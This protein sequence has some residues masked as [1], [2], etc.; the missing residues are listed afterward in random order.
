MTDLPEDVRER[1]RLAAI[2]ADADRR[3]VGDH[4]L[5]VADAAAAVAYEAGVAARTVRDDSR[6]R[7]T[8]VVAALDDGERFEEGFNRAYFRADDVADGEE[9][10]TIA[11]DLAALLGICGPAEHPAAQS[12]SRRDPDVPVPPSHAVAPDAIAGV[13]REGEGPHRFPGAESAARGGDFWTSS[14]EYGCGAWLGGSASAPADDRRDPRYE[15]AY[16]DQRGAGTCP[17]NPLT[18]PPGAES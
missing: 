8:E 16:G 17:K 12:D 4:L 6:R 9:D 13:S 11:A 14:C 7:L 15:S 1:A 5:R 3:A 18:P 2:G 10:A